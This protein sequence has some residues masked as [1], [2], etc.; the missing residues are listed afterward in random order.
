[1]FYVNDQVIFT[2]RIPFTKTIQPLFNMQMACLS[3][4][5]DLSSYSDISQ[6]EKD[7]NQ[8]FFKCKLID[9]VDTTEVYFQFKIDIF[10]I[11]L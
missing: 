10:Y 2:G 9:F 11:K 6:F 7:I 3:C 4:Y 8:H 5:F 1:M